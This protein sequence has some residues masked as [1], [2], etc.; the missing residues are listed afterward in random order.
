VRLAF[1][2]EFIKDRRTTGSVTPSSRFLV[3]KMVAPV[4]NARCVVELGGGNGCITKALLKRMEPDTKLF[5]FETNKRFSKILKRMKDKRLV[6]INDS[7]ERIDFYLKK[8]NV[9]KADYVV[10]GLPL[11]ALPGH[12]GEKIIDEV[13]TTLKPGGAYIQFQYSLTWYFR[14]KKRFSRVGL[15]FTPFNIPPA[16]V[17]ICKL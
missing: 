17:Y 12:V 1:F 8:Y 6:V 4:Q 5:C 16:F 11:V 14:L 9:K 2:K 3:E 10:S 13:V 7:A 15:G